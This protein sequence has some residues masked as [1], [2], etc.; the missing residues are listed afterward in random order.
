MED[1]YEL[2]FTQ[3]KPW[4]KALCILLSVI[5]AFGTFVALTV[6]SSRL[7]GW[8][9]IQSMLSAYASEIVDTK[10]AIAVNKESMLADRN[11]IDLKNKDGSNTLYLFSEPISFTD[12]NGNLKTKDISVEKQQDKKLKSKGYDYANGQNDYRI[13]FSKDISKGLLVEFDGGS[14]S[15]VPQTDYKSLAGRESTSVLLNEEFETFEYSGA[16]GAGTNLKFYPQLNGIK[17]EIVLDSNIG[18]NAFSFELNTKNCNAVLNDDGTV[19]L[20]SS[21]DESVVQT[22]SAPYAYDSEYVEGEMNSHYINCIYSLDKMSDNE[23]VLTI[24]VDE[25]WLAS[26]STVYPVTIDPTTSKISNMYDLPIHKNRTTTGATV[27]ANAVGLSEEFVK[28]Y[29]L[30]K[31]QKPSE[32]K[33][34]ATINSAYYWSRELTGRTSTFKCG[35]HKIT[36]SWNENTV[37]SSRP[38][39]SSSLVTSRNINSKSTD[40]ENNPYWY[41]FNI[42]SLVQEWYTGTTNYGFL[43]KYE[44]DSTAYNLRTFA[45]LEYSTSLWRPYTVINYTNDTTAPT[46]SVTKSTTAWTNGSVKLTASATDAASGLH[47]TP[48]SFSSST[49]ASWGT[50]KE[51]SYSTNTKLYVSARDKAGNSTTKT[52]SITNIDKLKPN[53]PA[54]SGYDGKWTN[55][56]VTITASSTDQAATDSYGCSGV[57]YYSFSTAE[58][59]YSWQTANSKTF[60]EST[61]VFI[62]SKDN[63]QNTSAYKKVDIKIDKTAPTTPTITGNTEDWKNDDVTITASSTDTASGV[64]QYSFSHEAGKYNWQNTNTY[65]ASDKSTLYVYAKDNAG[66]ISSPKVVDLKIDKIAPSGSASVDN[67]T[68]WATRVQ[69]TADAADDLAGSGLH[70]KPYSFSSNKESQTWQE[71]S[72]YTVTRNGTYYIHVRDSANNVILLDTVVVNNIDDDTPYIKNIDAQNEENKTIITVTAEDSQSGVGKYSIDNGKTWQDSN[73]F[74]IEKDSLNYI[75]VKVKDNVGHISSKTKY[76]DF[77]KPQLYYENEGSRVGIYNPNPNC[78]DYTIYYKTDMDGEWFKYTKPLENTDELT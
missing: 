15:I 50:T 32:I 14:Y 63:A 68:D 71:E 20:L 41:K 74:E 64:S 7:Q 25:D 54:Y 67:S 44:T 29:S 31:F 30:I 37:W 35:L 78:N 38:T 76:Y 43:L 42:K 3:H 69:L 59:S 58:G 62:Y 16:Y 28:S 39:Y 47:S 36:S 48:Y 27:D 60:S 23:Y 4:K 8:L 72:T 6:G 70:S 52:I 1:F 51:K 46:L 66:N 45:Q 33:G 21:E 13:N 26:R 17:D 9:G 65:T 57:G 11:V 49:T 12:E 56:N 2:N 40:A 75:A 61:S 77:V 24:N 22:F 19:S 73:V 10:D 55:K 5:I 18:K 34:Y 53:T